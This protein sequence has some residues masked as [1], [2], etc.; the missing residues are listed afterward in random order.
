MLRLNLIFWMSWRHILGKKTKEANCP[1]GG[2]HLDLRTESVSKISLSEVS[3]SSSLLWKKAFN[4]TRQRSV[5]TS[6]LIENSLVP[7]AMG[8]KFRPLLK[9]DFSESVSRRFSGTVTTVLWLCNVVSLVICGP[10]NC[11]SFWFFV[12]CKWCNSPELSSRVLAR[13]DSTET[14]GQILESSMRS[15]FFFHAML[16]GSQ[17]LFAKNEM[18]LTNKFFSAAPKFPITLSKVSFL[19]SLNYSK[20]IPRLVDSFRNLHLF[21]P[22]VTKT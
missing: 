17:W 13:I 6:C 14:T 20:M 15:K 4:W 5:S 3:E 10:I 1:C 2:V 22:N 9:T 21:H 12:W 19:I 18:Y 16:W 8:T 11:W 7:L